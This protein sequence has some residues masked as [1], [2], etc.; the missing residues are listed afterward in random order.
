MEGNDPNN[1]LFAIN[2][3]SEYEQEEKTIIGISLYMT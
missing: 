3:Y 2:N 1:D